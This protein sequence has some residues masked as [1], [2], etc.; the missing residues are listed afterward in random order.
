MYLLDTNICIAVMNGDR[1][2]ISVFNRMFP[3]CFTSTI[4]I[5][6]LYKG[7]RL[8]RLVEQNLQSL[9]QLTEL[10][11]VS[12]FDSKAAAEFGLIQQE[13]REQGRV[14]GEMDVLI[15]AVARSQGA[16]LVTNNTRDFLN[17]PN[18]NLE[19]WLISQ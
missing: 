6:E 13:L 5:A 1:Q 12:A 18:L 3:Q 16:T 9:N 17:I 14:T 15:A 7:V 19:D 8:S 11:D 10:L 4:V 2:A